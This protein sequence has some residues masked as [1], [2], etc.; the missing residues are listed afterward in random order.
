MFGI[1]IGP[2]GILPVD[3][4]QVPPAPLVASVN[5]NNYILGKNILSTIE[6]WEKSLK[7][8]DTRYRDFCQKWSSSLRSVLSFSAT[9]AGIY[10]CRLPLSLVAEDTTRDLG[11][12]ILVCAAVVY[13]FHS[14]GGYFAQQVERHIDRQVPQNNITL[15]EGDKRAAEKRDSKNKKTLFKSGLFVLGVVVQLACSLAATAIWAWLIAK[16]IV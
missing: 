4:F 15:T 10:A 8:R 11:W 9:L 6:D 14:V 7:K 1:Q 16:G 12:F 2:L 13:I 3:G 5:F